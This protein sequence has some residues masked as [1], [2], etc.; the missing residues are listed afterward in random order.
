MST[1][2]TFNAIQAARVVGIIRAPSPD[3]AIEV[4][5]AL[6]RGGLR[7]IEV[8]FNTPDALQAIETLVK[9][10][11][12]TI[13]AGT[14]LDPAD[15]TRV[16]QT[17]AS[18]MV[19]P[20]LNP[21]VVTAAVDQGLVV[22]P[23]VFTPSETALAMSLGAHLLKL[24]PAS[25]AGI[26]MMKAISEPLPEAAWLPAGGIPF[27]EIPTWIEAGAVAVGLGSSLTGGDPEDVQRR[28]QEVS[29]IVKGL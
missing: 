2:S 24:F 27:A 3:H 14:V 22:G 4:G 18:F 21:D 8:S 15:V 13:G 17:G 6:L 23:G 5:R 26:E 1:E 12:G 25:S 10:G 29:G 16:A 20:N 19:A 28:A 11:E 9:D 7:V